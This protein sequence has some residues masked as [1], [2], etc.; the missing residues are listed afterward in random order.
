MHLVSYS[1]RNHRPHASVIPFSD[2]LRT[3]H[4][5]PQFGHSSASDLGWTAATVHEEATTFYLNPYLRHFD[6]YL[7]RF[8]FEIFYKLFKERQQEIEERRARA[9]AAVFPRSRRR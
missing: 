5:I 3:C 6:F 7:M 1:S 9:V 4:L 8:K 2:I